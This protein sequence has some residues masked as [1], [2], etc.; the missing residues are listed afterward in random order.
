[1]SD[2]GRL[3]AN[4]D[5]VRVWLGQVASQFGNGVSLVATPLLVL[6]LTDSP[7]QAGLV[8]AMRSA[9]YI[10]L[11]LPAGALVDRWNRRIVL[12]CCDIARGLAMGSVPLAWMLGLL[13]FWQL[14]VVG[15][16]Q[17]IAVSFSNIAQTAALP[18]LV[19]REQIAAAQS[20]NTASNGIAALMGPGI[21]GLIVGLGGTTEEG[22]IIA[23]LV[24]AT[25]Y[26][27]SMT[28]LASVRR[29]FQSARPSG[30]RHMRDEIVEGL[31]YLWAD[32]PIRLLAI[33]NC[34]H[35]MCV[36]TV[37]VLPVVVFG[38]DELRADASAIGFVV[39]SAGLGG[40]LG[41]A[42]TPSLRRHLSVGWHMVL[43]VVLHG[44]GIGLVASATT[45]PHAMAGMAVVG[46]AEAM[47]SIVQ[48][49]YRL[50]TIPDALQGRVNSVYRLGSFLAMTVGTAVGG[51][52]VE[53]VG[54][55]NALWVMAAYVMLIAV[56]TARSDVRKL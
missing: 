28:M 41:S 37:V 17:G 9:P 34:L 33:V 12:I 39:A 50:A 35:R 36:G 24:D 42:V 15:L 22:A 6:A 31:R 11:G 23:Y 48:V 52:L 4:T 53:S 8:A 49:S 44:A 46:V 51:L 30:S 1:M 2:S 5:F 16:V 40:L 21:G 54:A 27:L 25:T 10:V 55:R 14:L 32:R 26:L 19:R 47:T 43:T 45:L 20:L 29:P 13:G 3:L 7:A 56:G 38:R 18:R